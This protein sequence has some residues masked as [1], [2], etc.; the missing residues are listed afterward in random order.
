MSLCHGGD[1]PQNDKGPVRVHPLLAPDVEEQPNESSHSTR[2]S[3]IGGYFFFPL[4]L[5]GACVS[6]EAAT[7]FTPLEVLGL[8]N[9]FPAF[10]ATDFGLFISTAW[11][12]SYSFR[13]QRFSL[14]TTHKKKI[15]VLY[16]NIPKNT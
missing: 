2:T 14:V 7:L 3:R 4:D 8:L 10:E 11:H 9:I 15:K 16:K 1:S 6:A 12:I 13:Y 5:L